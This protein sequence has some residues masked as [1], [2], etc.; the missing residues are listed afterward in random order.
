MEGEDKEKNGYK[1]NI[2]IELGSKAEKK[3]DA[4]STQGH[5]ERYGKGKITK[6]TDI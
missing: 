4:L 3:G 1:D 5:R 6:E 2:H